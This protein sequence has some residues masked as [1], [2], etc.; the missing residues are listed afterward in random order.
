MGRVAAIG[1]RVRVDGLS[2]AGVLVRAAEDPPAV[3]AEWAA[4]PDDVVVV[5]LT[6]SAARALPVGGRGPLRVV[7]PP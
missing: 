1:E 3:R 5:I 6:D 2:L 7:M 4:L